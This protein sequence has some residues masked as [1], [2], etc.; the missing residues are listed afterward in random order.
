MDR[1]VPT[2]AAANDADGDALSDEEQAD[3]YSIE[4]MAFYLL[5]KGLPPSCVYG[6]HDGWPYERLASMFRYLKR[7][8]LETHREHV[9]A[10]AIG[11]SSVAG[12]KVVKRYLDDTGRT[13]GKMRP[14]RKSEVASELSKLMGMLNGA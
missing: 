5:E 2:P 8:D 13:I 6:Y 10:V 4:E 3:D 1:A 9:V 14:Q 11:A 12:G 7:R